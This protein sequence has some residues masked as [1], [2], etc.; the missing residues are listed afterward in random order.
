[1]SKNNTSNTSYHETVGGDAASQHA[2]LVLPD[3]HLPLWTPVEP[4]PQAPQIHVSTP[5]RSHCV[6][7]TSNYLLSEIS[8]TFPS[9]VASPQLDKGQL[10]SGMWTFD[11]KRLIDGIR[12]AIQPRQIFQL[13]DG[14]RGT[15][16]LQFT[17]IDKAANPFLVVK[18]EHRS[19]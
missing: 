1:M 10:V 5:E 4:T 7:I 3:F 16:F 17:G 2:V 14:K 15:Y 11:G 9:F 8:I 13:V 12:V 18:K 6:S 19:V